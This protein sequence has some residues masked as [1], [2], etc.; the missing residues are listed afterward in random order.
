MFLRKAGAPYACKVL[1]RKELNMKVLKQKLKLEHSSLDIESVIALQFL[2][3]QFHVHFQS[4]TF[5]PSQKTDMEEKVRAHKKNFS[6]SFDAFF[7]NF[8]VGI[9]ELPVVNIAFL[10]SVCTYLESNGRKSHTGWREKLG[11]F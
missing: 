1:Q 11:C 7:I 4:L 3:I 10:F 8:D 6:S 5:F 9:T 2:I